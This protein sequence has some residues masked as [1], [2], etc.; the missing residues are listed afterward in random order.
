MRRL[1]NILDN[2]PFFRRDEANYLAQMIHYL[3][4][5]P[6]VLEIGTFKGLSSI[7]MAKQRQDVSITTIDP[8]VGIP[9][10]HALSSSFSEALFNFS[11]FGV[12]NQITHAPVSSRDYKTNNKFNLLFIDGD[13]TYDGVSSDFFRFKDNVLPGGFIVFHDYGFQSG[14]TRFCND[15]NLPHKVHISFFIL[16]NDILPK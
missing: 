1:S 5:H 9:S 15:L 3:P 13:H 14:V 11:K 6:K 4:P 7:L 8:H 12:A 10:C 2:N 16:K